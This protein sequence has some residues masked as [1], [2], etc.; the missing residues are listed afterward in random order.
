MSPAYK[1]TIEYENLQH[2]NFR[3]IYPSY[4]PS[5]VQDSVNV[6]DQSQNLE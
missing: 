1:E 5:S 4:E 3:R 2:E 6:T